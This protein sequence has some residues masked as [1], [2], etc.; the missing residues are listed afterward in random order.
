V[1]CARLPLALRLAA[2]LAAARPG[3][4]LAGLAAELADEQRRLE[5]LDADGD[6]RTANAGRALLVGPALG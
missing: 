5:L 3:V 4:P 1:Q 2:E 6:P